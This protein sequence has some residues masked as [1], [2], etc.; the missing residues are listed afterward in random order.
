MKV[1][2]FKITKQIEVILKELNSDKLKRV[3]FEEKLKVEL[4][5][6]TLED[7]KNWDVNL[8]FNKMSNTYNI[9]LKRIEN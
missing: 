1:V 4:L 9:E 8:S 3:E 7:P 2:D 5:Q 6:G